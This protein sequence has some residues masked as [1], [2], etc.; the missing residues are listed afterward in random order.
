MNSPTAGQPEAPAL[1]LALGGKW[2]LTYGTAPCPVCQPER[3]PDQTALTLRDGA[4]G[5]LMNCKKSGC[6]FRDILAAAG[7]KPGTFAP[8]DPALTAVRRANELDDLKKRAVLALQVWHESMPIAGT[9][10]ET[11]LRSRGITC[12]LPDTLRFHPDC[13]HL[14]AQRFPAL[15]AR[16]GGAKG[17]AVH[18]TYLAADGMHKAAVD[19]PKAM[20]GSVAGGA[21]RLS[22]GS[23]DL[24]VVEGIETGLSLLCGPLGRPAVVWAAL[25]TSGLQ[26]LLLP[27]QPGH[28]IIASDGDDAGRA[29]AQVLKKRAVG[30]GWA[31]TMLPAPDGL[32]WNDV[33]LDKGA[34]A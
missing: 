33:I 13:W 2:H 23:G 19:P 5:L 11:Y 4:V 24:V 29:A 17:F 28:L 16:V 14:T 6:A 12:A 18:R 22:R 15:V 25:S 3:R 8:P 26:G 21:V 7:V 20:L 30:L 9:L 10:A 1:T 27:S 31:V 34:A 32:D